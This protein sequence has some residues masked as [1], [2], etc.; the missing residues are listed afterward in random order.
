MK[1]SRLFILSIVVLVILSSVTVTLAQDK[2]NLVLWHGWQDAE[3][4]GLLAMIDAFQ[5]ANPDITIEQ[6]YNNSGTINDSFMAAAG[7]GEGPDMII[8]ANDRVGIWAKAGLVL[9]VTDLVDDELMAQVSDAGWGTFTFEDSIWGFPESAKTL[10]FF[11]NQ[12]LVPDA[13]ETWADV[14][15]ISEE[16]AADGFTGLVFQNGFFHSAGFLYSMGGALMD[17]DGNA[18]FPPDSEGRT[19]MEEYLAFH[20]MMY[21]LGQDPASGVIVAGDSPYP[22]FQTGEVAMVYDGIWNLAQFESDLGDDLGVALMPKLDNGE[23]PALFAQSVGFYV[24]ANVTD[25]AKLDAIVKWAKFITGP[26]G[27]QIAAEKAGH[28]PVNPAVMLENPHLQ[29]F[30]EQFALGTPFPNREE[31]AQFWGPMADAIAAVSAGGED[32]ATAAANA[33]DL[34]QASID[35]VHAKEAE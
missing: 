11:Y 33:Y 31:L 18:A 34:I 9:D 22:G 28:L 1:H 35:D 13:P 24:N 20:K 16:L 23:V 8:F 29:T 12:S 7:A 4:D 30:A 25:Q 15:S 21:E 5:A 32:P 26:E 3:G 14:L 19:A 2:V 6:V 27:Q 10:A 17:A